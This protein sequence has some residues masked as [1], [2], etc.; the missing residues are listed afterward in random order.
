VNK[1][2]PFALERHPMSALMRPAA[3]SWLQRPTALLGATAGLSL[4]AV[5]AALVTQHVFN[6]L[7]C[8]W[9][10]LQRLI[11]LLVAAAALLGL[12]VPARAGRRLAGGAVL[13]FGAAGAA[14]ALW[15][16]F[17]AA[18]SASCAMSLADKLMGATGLDFA[19]PEVFAAYANCADAKA[20][21]LGVPY[22]FYS[23]ALFA[24]ARVAGLR[25]LRLAR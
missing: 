15:Q 8:P 6:M 4:A 18:A 3:R 19:V 1:G 17:V 14:A 9:C 13:L 11:F 5:A 12:L 10:V 16:H 22:E 21:L 20:W 25:V 24:A 23:L 7:P 2:V